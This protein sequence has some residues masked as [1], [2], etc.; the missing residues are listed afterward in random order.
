MFEFVVDL[1]G[2]GS[3]WS[4]GFP[5]TH[6]FICCGWP[7]LQESNQGLNHICRTVA[8]GH[9]EYHACREDNLLRNFEMWVGGLCNLSFP[10]ESG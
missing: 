4:R 5:C 1:T 6:C 10:R 3:C 9:H 7:V 2:T 8:G